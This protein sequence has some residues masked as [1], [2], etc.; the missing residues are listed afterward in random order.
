METLLNIIYYI[1]PFIVLLG[2]LVLCMNL[3][4]LSLRGGWV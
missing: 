3:D 4:I 1:V 2:I